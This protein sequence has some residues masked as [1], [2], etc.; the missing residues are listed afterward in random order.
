MDRVKERRDDHESDVK[1]GDGGGEGPVRRWE[2]P[3]ERLA[4]LDGSIVE[5][6]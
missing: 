1:A 2:Q 3:I 5:N 6:V 4:I